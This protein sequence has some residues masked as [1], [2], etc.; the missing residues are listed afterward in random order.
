MTHISLVYCR[1]ASGNCTFQQLTR[2]YL[3][4]HWSYPHITHTTHTHTHTHTHSHASLLT[5]HVPTMCEVVKENLIIWEQ[6]EELVVPLL[7]H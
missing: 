3:D 1:K 2:S 5:I 6:N 7:E 4:L